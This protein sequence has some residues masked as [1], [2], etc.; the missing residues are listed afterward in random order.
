MKP[1]YYL[2]FILGLFLIGAGIFLATFMRTVITGYR[3]VPLVPSNL[4]QGYIRQAISAQ[5]QPFTTIGITI[6]IIGALLLALSMVEI[7]ESIRYYRV[8]SRKDVLSS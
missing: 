7:I 2:L 5:T 8:H 3:E 6:L 1:K 4:T